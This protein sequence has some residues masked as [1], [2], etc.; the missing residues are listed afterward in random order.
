MLGG[1]HGVKVTLKFKI[2]K[3][4]VRFVCVIAVLFSVMVILGESDDLCKMLIWKSVAGLVAWLG[5]MGVK[6]TMTDDELNE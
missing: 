5:V 1:F 4:F 2:M 3:K 6:W